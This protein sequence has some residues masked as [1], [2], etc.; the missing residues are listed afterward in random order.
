[1]KAYKSVE[2]NSFYQM[3]MVRLA[4]PFYLPILNGLEEGKKKKAY[5]WN[6]IS[7]V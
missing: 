7:I 4:N 6:R 5:T 1:V 2:V 3:K